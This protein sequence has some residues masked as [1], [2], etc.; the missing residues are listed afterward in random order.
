MTEHYKLG[1]KD[2]R[3]NVDFYTLYLNRLEKLEEKLRELIIAIYNKARIR[4]LKDE[5]TRLR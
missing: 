5:K 4:T 2:L 1:A 3:I